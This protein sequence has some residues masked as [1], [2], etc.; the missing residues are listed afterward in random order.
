MNKL[1]KQNRI[2]SGIVE[3]LLRD[4]KRGLE[5]LPEGTGGKEE[6][7]EEEWRRSDEE[8]EEAS[9][10]L[11]TS[12]PSPKKPPKGKKRSFEPGNPLSTDERQL[13]PLPLP[14]RFL[15]K[16]IRLG[17]GESLARRQAEVKVEQARP[18]F[19]FCE[20]NYTYFIKHFIWTNSFSSISFC[21][22]TDVLFERKR[23][24]GNMKHTAVVV[25]TSLLPTVRRR[26]LFLRRK[27][28][29]I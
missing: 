21:V 19:I 5:A 9:P 12:Q 26:Y 13:F 23:E 20:G 6:E 7:K 22:K 18:A 17:G 16:K 10:S 8:E 29:Q 2:F 25:M 28:A 4:Q 14:P 3:I 24:E 15:E 27:S 11:G 1:G